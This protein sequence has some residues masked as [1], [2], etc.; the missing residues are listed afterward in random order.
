M[1]IIMK[2]RWNY[3]LGLF[4]VMLGLVTG[5]GSVPEQ[6]AQ[7]GN[8]AAISNAPQMDSDDTQE[9]QQGSEDGQTED[10]SQKPEENAGDS[11]QKPEENTGKNKEDDLSRPEDSEDIA[12]NNSENNTNLNNPENPEDIVNNDFENNAN[13]NSPENPEDISDNDSENNASQGLEGNSEDNTQE[14]E[15]NPEDT[16]PKNTISEDGEYISKEE[17]AAYLHEFD[18]LPNNYI[19]KTEAKDLGWVSKE[20]N[21]YKVAP[22]KSIGGDYFGNHEGILP[23]EKGRQYYECDIDTDGTYR[24][25]KR[26]VYSND[27]LIY[28]TEDHY[29]TFELLY[30]KD[31]RAA[32]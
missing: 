28:Y 21:L 5:C 27:G 19:T 22:G 26:I 6:P 31:G 13:S 15:E 8:S 9:K 20:G 24:G 32:E 10:I 12:D 7:N 23:K 3:I 29:T 16:S 4:L 30:T 14:P 18:H 1:E 2:K 25:S 17:V 11:T